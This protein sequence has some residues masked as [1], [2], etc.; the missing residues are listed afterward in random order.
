VEEH[1]E[2][3][4]P[5]AREWGGRAARRISPRG[6][7]V[8]SRTWALAYERDPARAE[9]ELAARVRFDRAYDAWLAAIAEVEEAGWQLFG[10]AWAQVAGDLYRLPSEVRRPALTWDSRGFGRRSV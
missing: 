2:S 10:A 3:V 8:I 6:A 1:W 4:S 5:A 9:V 7:S